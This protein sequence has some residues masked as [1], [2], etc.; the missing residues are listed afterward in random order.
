MVAT[1]NFSGSR[2]SGCTD[3]RRAAY[4]GPLPWGIVDCTVSYIIVPCGCSGSCS[5]RVS[6]K[7]RLTY[8]KRIVGGSVRLRTVPELLF[9]SRSM[10]G[11]FHSLSPPIPRSLKTSTY[12]NQ[13]AP[14]LYPRHLVRYV[15]VT[16][17]SI[18]ILKNIVTYSVSPFAQPMP[19]QRSLDGGHRSSY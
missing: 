13:V 14:Y 18:A 2:C 6:G 1:G 15:A 17:P 11:P 7:C 19:V 5:W 3:W 16:H 12:R 4:E 10:K 9:T 8:D